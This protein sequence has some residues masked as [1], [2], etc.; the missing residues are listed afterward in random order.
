[1]FKVKRNIHYLRHELIAMKVNTSILLGS[2][3]SNHS[4]ILLDIN[5]IVKEQD[6]VTC[7]SPR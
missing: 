2:A 6:H 7:K 3:Y 5:P 4:L 1:M